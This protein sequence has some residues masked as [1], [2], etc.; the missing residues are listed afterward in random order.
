MPSPLVEYLFGSECVTRSSNASV[1]PS[2]SLSCGVP[3]IRNASAA[4]RVVIVRRFV[5]HGTA[6]P[7]HAHC[8]FVVL[9]RVIRLAAKTSY[10][11]LFEPPATVNFTLTVPVLVMLAVKFVIHTLVLEKQ[12]VV[13]VPR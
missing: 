11:R 5:T 6:W 10:G 12:E 3:S 7:I 8:H 13:F 2:A 1:R 9:A 4:G